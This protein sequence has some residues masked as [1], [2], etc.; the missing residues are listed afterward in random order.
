MQIGNTELYQIRNGKINP[1]QDRASIFVKLESQNP[2]KS[3]KDRMVY[4]IVSQ[5][6]ETSSDE[7]TFV[8]ASSGN[9]GTSL[10]YFC[11]QFNFNCITELKL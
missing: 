1:Y 5:A 9:T 8:S 4:H 11:K 7:T 6:K 2:T 10:A 3:I